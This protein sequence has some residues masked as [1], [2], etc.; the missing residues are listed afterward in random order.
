MYVEL[1]GRSAFSFLQGACVPEEYAETAAKLGL[2]AMALLD[3]DG[4]YG[5]PRFH[6]AMRKLGLHAHVGAEVLGTDG[7]RYPLLVKDRRGYQ[8]LCRLIT[9]TKLRTQKHPKCGFEAAAT[10]EEFAEFSQ[11]LLCLTGDGSGPLALAIRKGEGRACLERLV[12]I[13]G[14]G[15]VHVEIQRHFD[16]D[17]EARNEAV[18]ALARAEPLSLV[19]TNGPCYALSPQRQILGVFTCLHHK[20]TLE[21]AGRLLARNSERHLKSGAVMKRLFADHPEAIQN[22][23]EVSTQLAFELS[24]LGYE[25]PHYPVPRGESESQF[26]H[27]RTMESA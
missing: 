23:R 14:R 10:P 6:F 27:A 5:S 22:T 7:A 16:A 13:F 9:W 12:R 26:L 20:V 8:N 4:V 21:T 25:V 15:N 1:H 18:I 19:A 11:G 24:D 3:R 17:E 2:P